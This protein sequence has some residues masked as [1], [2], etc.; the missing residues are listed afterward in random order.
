MGSTRP[1]RPVRYPAGADSTEQVLAAAHAYVAALSSHDASR[2]PLADRAWRIENGR[3]A[4][5]SGAAIRASLESEVMH[6]VQSIADEQW[7]VSGDAAAVFY[8]LV[9]GTGGSHVSMRVAERFRIVDGALVEIEAVVA[10]IPS[11]D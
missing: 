9:V 7:F 4:G 6:A 5:A 1:D 2:V 8:T 3:D 10:Q 11:G